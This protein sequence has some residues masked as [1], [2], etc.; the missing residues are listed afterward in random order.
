MKKEEFEKSLSRLQNMAK[1]SGATQL[2]HTPSDSEPGTWPGG[3]QEE[4]NEHEDNIG[5]DGTDYQTVR[6]SL[7]N[8]V[9][10]SQALT[11]A[12]VAIAEGRNPRPMIGDKVTKGEQLTPA[13]N[14]AL[15][16]NFMGTGDTANKSKD[17]PS[18]NL[19]TPGEQGGQSAAPPTHAGSKKDGEVEE[20][21]KK[22]L[23]QSVNSS[24]EL[25][26]GVEASAFLYEFARAIG[27]ALGTA[28]ANVTKSI[29]QAVNQ[30]AQR[31]ENIEKSLAA[32]DEFNKSLA[33]AVVGI[34]E[35]L[36]ASQEVGLNKA[37]EPAGGPKSNFRPEAGPQ[38]QGQINYVEKSYGP[39]GLEA[40]LSKSQVRDAM[41]DMVQKGSQGISHMDVLKFEHTGEIL[42]QTRDRV[43]AHLKG[44]GSN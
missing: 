34:G 20:D 27:D 43:L 42:P 31:V 37:L 17:K 23:E 25:Q 33:D 21:A 30:L 15:K 41:V 35:A 26:K 39:G 1:G 29:T 10:K 22:S 32:G 18:D 4:Q 14:W 13:E 44:Q 3:R 40:D 24:L 28:E 2:Y 12:E 36:G 19:D 6:K 16:A 7:A 9:R 11:P 38:N 8:K 5:D